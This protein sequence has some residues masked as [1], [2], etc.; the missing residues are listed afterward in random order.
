MWASSLF[1]PSE[2]CCMLLLSL[3]DKL[4]FP[5]LPTLVFIFSSDHEGS[6][7]RNFSCVTSN[8]SPESP[9]LHFFRAVWW[10]FKDTKLVKSP[11]AKKMPGMQLGTY[12]TWAFIFPNDSFSELPSELPKSFWFKPHVKFSGMSPESDLPT[13]IPHGHPRP[14]PRPSLFLLPYCSWLWFTLICSHISGY[15]LPNP[16]AVTSSHHSKTINWLQSSLGSVSFSLFL[17]HH[18]GIS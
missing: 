6:P 16:F 2:L 9:C 4:F 5:F 15:S 3:Q 1:F 14:W 17:S 8:R 7:S 11:G 12:M 13:L 18:H 10:G